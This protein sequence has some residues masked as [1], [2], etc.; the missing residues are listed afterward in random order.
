MYKILMSGKFALWRRIQWEIAIREISENSNRLT[1]YD[2]KR[3]VRK[4]RR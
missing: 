2:T 4:T 3:Q 1:L